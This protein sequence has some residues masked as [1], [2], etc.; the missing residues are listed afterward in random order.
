MS[1]ETQPLPDDPRQGK[2]YYME[3][4]LLRRALTALLRLI[5]RL[6]TVIKVSGVENLPQ[7][8]GVVLVA[9]HLTEFDVFPMQFV[10]PRLIFFMGKAELF[11]NPLIDPVFRRLGGFP[12][13]RGERDDWAV[14]HALR[15]LEH[16]QVLGMFPEGKRSRGRGL[17]T[18]KTGAA[19]FAIQSGAPIVPMAVVGTDRVF[20]RF[21][22]RT[23]VT[24]IVGAPI[25][26]GKDDSP[27]ELTDRAM[28]T[29]AQMLPRRLR[30]VYAERPAG[31]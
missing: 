6:F 12:V 16:G 14:Q 28:F 10:L 22:R 9:N 11:K 8:G 26:P 30:G 5:F 13:Y 24:I 19:R 27:L 4:T 20:R 3:D 31:F 23:R 1:A 18:A 2:R 17:R 15:L 7:S 29:L 25:Y 21:P